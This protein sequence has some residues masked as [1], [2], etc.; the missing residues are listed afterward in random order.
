MF[1]KLQQYVKCAK[2][3]QS[4]VF[5]CVEALLLADKSRPALAMGPSIRVGGM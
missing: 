3:R 1:R 4:S 5:V 2:T